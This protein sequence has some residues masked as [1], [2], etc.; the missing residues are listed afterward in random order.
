[1]FKLLFL[2]G[3]GFLLFKLIQ[4]DSKQKAA[5]QQENDEKLATSGEMVKDPVCGTYVPTGSDI[6][7]KEGGKTHYFCSYECRD[8]F[9]RQKNSQQKE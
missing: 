9:L 5:K 1:M 4:G 2:I 7:V 8:A 3:A 6:R